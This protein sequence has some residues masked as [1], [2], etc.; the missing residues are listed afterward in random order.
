M[1]KWHSLLEFMQFPLKILFLATIL[2]GVGSAIINP[3]VAFLWSVTN[4]NVIRTSE[5]FRY[6]GA[7]LIDIFPVLVYFKVLSKKFEDSV[8]VI[9]GIVAF[10][11]INISMTFFLDTSFPSYFYKEVLGISINFDV[12]PIS[13]AGI[14]NPYNMGIFSLIISYFITMKCYQ[15]SRHH[16]VYGIFSFIDH[17]AWAVVTILIFSV[18]SGVALAFVWPYVIQGLNI[19]FD[20]IAKDITNPI[21][22][23]LYG[24]F[25]R[26]CAI[27]GLVDIPRNIFWYTSAGGT[28]MNEVGLNFYGDVA[29]W[30]AQKAQ[31][32]Q[33]TTTGGFIT[34][35]YV[36]NL[37]IIPAFYIAYY[38]LCTSRK[39]RGRYWLFFLLAILLSIFCG[40]PLPAEFLILLL[41]PMLYG[42]YIV[43]VGLL[44]AFLHIFNVI[45]GY[46]FSDII[47]LANPGAGL[48]LIQYF[49]SAYVLPSL[50]KMLIIGLGVAI[51]FAYLTRAYFSK[52]AFGLFQFID[53]EGTTNA[54]IDALGGID[55]ILDAQSTPDKLIV[56]LKN[57]ELIDYTVLQS[58][59]AY[60]ILEAK[61]GY[62]IRLGN[63]S[64]IIRNEI[65][66][67]SQSVAELNQRKRRF[68]LFHKKA[69]EA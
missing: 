37:F 28:W 36:I 55:N 64:T 22:L 3:N 54:I 15:R 63:M 6:I 66:R 23:M 60:L 31:G 52:Y 10:L 30:T 46:N 24:M 39:D 19:F 2:L 44:F 7:F 58:Y 32:V 59:G 40:N 20:L 11:L 27:F 50:M 14:V 9:V 62:L 38:S 26:I 56:E 13:G 53:K 35:Y 48:D 25:E 68:K 45:I 41:S 8:P 21:N 67:R 16:S 43:I 1:S 29:I 51:V 49:R 47:M 34:P 61:G 42:I 33:A 18:I 69:E 65:L 57:R 17:D 5:M 12:L 4:Q